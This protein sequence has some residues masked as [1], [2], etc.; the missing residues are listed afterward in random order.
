[1]DR[2][3]N[4]DVLKKAIISLNHIPQGSEWEFVSF[5]SFGVRS[6]KTQAEVNSNSTEYKQ[7]YNQI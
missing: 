5:I 3:D 2:L 7:D 1:M 4:V 6:Q